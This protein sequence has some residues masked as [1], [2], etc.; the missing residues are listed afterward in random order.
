MTIGFIG[1]GIMGAAMAANVR[2]AGFALAPWNRTRAKIDALRPLGIDDVGSPA[3]VARRAEIVG[4]C[5]TDTADVEQVLFGVDGV[6]SGARPGLIVV[7]HSTIRADRTR[8]FAARLATQGVTLLDSPVSGGDV[9]ARDGTLSIMVGGDAEAFARCDRYFAAV[10]KTIVHVGPSG[11]GQVCKAC[12]QIAVAVNLAGACEAMAYGARHGLDLRKMLDVVKGG[13][14]G[15]WQLANLGPKI[16]DGDL[17]PGFMVDLALKDLAIVADTAGAP[18]PTVDRARRYLLDVADADER[19]GELGT[20]A[21][22]R[23]V[24]RATD[25]PIVT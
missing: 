12:N 13:A 25:T 19:G 6:A 4:V 14:G 24:E 16:L 10:G 5:V 23:G 1:L 2:R 17:R 3:A 15:S 7:D 11:A 21:M 18:L 9:G 8:E 20:Q 22:I